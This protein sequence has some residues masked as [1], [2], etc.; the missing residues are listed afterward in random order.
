MRHADEF[1]VVVMD[2]AGRHV[3]GEFQ[4]PANMRLVFLPPYSPKLNPAEHLWEVLR[5]DWFANTVFIDLNAVENMLSDGLFALESDIERVQRLTGF[6]WIT[7][8]SLN[9]K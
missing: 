3:A 1:I 5:E 2:Q 7:T 8:T 4:G 6:K 9:A